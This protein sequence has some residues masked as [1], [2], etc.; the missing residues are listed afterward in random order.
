SLGHVPTIG[1]SG[2]VTSFLTVIELFKNG[3]RLFQEAYDTYPTG[4]FKVASLDRWEYI[5]SGGEL[6]DDMKR[7]GDHQLSFHREFV[8]RLKCDYT[9][10]SNI[11]HSEYHL[12]IVQTKMTSFGPYWISNYTSANILKVMPVTSAAWKSVLLWDTAIRLVGRMSSRI[13]V[14]LPLCRNP[15]YLDLCIGYCRSFMIIGALIN[16]IPWP[17]RPIIGPWLSSYKKHRKLALK[18]LGPIISERLKRRKE[19]GNDLKEDPDDAIS[20]L[21]N[22]A[23]GE[24][25]KVENMAMRVLFMSFLAMHNTSMTL[26]NVLLDLAARPEVQEPLRQEAQEITSSEGWTKSAVAKMYKIDSFIRE[27]NRFSS[28]MAVAGVRRVC[29]PNGFKL[30]NG[31][32]LPYGSSMSVICDAVHCDAAFYEDPKKFDALRFYQ[33]GKKGLEEGNGTEYHVKHAFASLAPNW[34]F[35]GVGKHVCPGRFFAA[36]E[37]KASVAQILMNYDIALADEKRP[38]N[39]WV[40]HFCVPDHKARLLFRRKESKEPERNS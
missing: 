6:L 17:L 36:H 23:E 38:E 35:W 14:G 3:R 21:V 25:A 39:N 2:R 1:Y 10:K 13:L 15:E 33:L 28:I 4:L 8:E 22:E 37:L 12:K 27:S 32:T 19:R 30:S 7:A 24:D 18:Y 16:L 29:D 11:E 20:W 40:A 34:M 31:T 26:V 9:T 5:V